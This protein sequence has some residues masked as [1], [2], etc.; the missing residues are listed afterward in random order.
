MLGVPGMMRAWRRGAVALVNAPGARVADDKVA[1]TYVPA[2]TRYDLDQDPSLPNVPSFFCVDPKSCDH[3]LANMDTLVV[4]AANESGGC[5]LLI[6]AHA[7]PAQRAAF[8]EAVR[9]D[10]PTPRSSPG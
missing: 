2:L 8:A 5:G 4:K 10:P 7:T 1:Y 9:R 3:V 6:G